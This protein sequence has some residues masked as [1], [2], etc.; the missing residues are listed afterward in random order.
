MFRA[1]KAASRQSSGGG[2]MS[3]ANRK[4]QIRMSMRKGGGGAR[5]S[6]LPS[7]GKPGSTKP[8][9]S[10]VDHLNVGDVVWVNLGKKADQPR[11]CHAVAESRHGKKITVSLSDGFMQTGDEKTM[12]I[13]VAKIDTSN[14]KI[15]PGNKSLLQVLDD[16]SYAKVGSFS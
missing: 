13:S 9:A 8:G 14:P 10:W 5:A 3:L 16:A 11:W 6:V 7:S 15:V 12:E 2:R 4:S 1:N